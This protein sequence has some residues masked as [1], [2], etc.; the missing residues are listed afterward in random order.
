M[1]EI[2]LLL[3]EASSAHPEW[4][5]AAGIF[6]ALAIQSDFGGLEWDGKTAVAR[7]DLALNIVLSRMRSQWPDFG[8]DGSFEAYGEDGSTWIVVAGDDSACVLGDDPEA[9]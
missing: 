9:A 1:A 3:G 7:L 2:S 8:W 6:T 4:E 5:S